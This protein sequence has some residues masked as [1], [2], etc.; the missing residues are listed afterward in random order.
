LPKGFL[1]LSIFLVILLSFHYAYALPKDRG[2][3]FTAQ[4]VE[5]LQGGEKLYAEGDIIVEAETYLLYAQRAIYDRKRDFLELFHFKLFDFS[6]NA[7]TLGEHAFFDLRN[8]ELMSSK[9]FI[10]FKKEG[11]RLKAWEFK[12]NALNEYFAQRALITTC[13]LDCEREEFPPWSVEVR[14]LILTPE[15]YTSSKATYFR[16]KGVPLLYLPQKVYLPKMSLPLFEP[17]KR[18]FLFPNISQGNRLGL[19]LQL[20]YFIPLTDQIDFTIAPLYTTKRGLLWDLENQFALSNETKGV[21]KVRYLEDTKR[22]EYLTT[23]VP[24]NRYWATGKIDIASGKNWDL[25][26]DIDFVSDKDFLEE[27]NVGEGSFDRAKGLYLERF[28]R[29]LEDKS[30]DYRTSKL[31]FQYTRNSL[32]TRLQSA[33]LDYEGPGNKKEVLQPLAQLRLNLLPFSFREILPSLSLDYH[34]FYRKENY[35]GHRWGL[36]LELAYPFVY[37]VL[38]N[39]F[40]VNYKNFLY[41]LEEEGNFTKK[42]LNQNLFEASFTSYTLLSK[43]YTFGEE[44]KGLKFQHVLKPYVSFFYRE[45]TPKR[46]ENPLF[47]YED[48]LV[49][50]AKALEYGIWQFINLPTQRNFLAIKAYQQYDFTK[51]ER[52]VLLTKPEDRALSDLYLQVLSQWKGRFSLRYD[53]AYNFYG[54]GLRKHSLNL[55]LREYILSSID[56]TYQEDEAWKTRQATLALAHL[57]RNNLALRYYVSRNLLKEETSE[58]KIEALYLHDCYLLGLGMSITPRDTKFYFKVDLKGLGGLGDRSMGLP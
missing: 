49:K 4:R 58:Q 35:Y 5:L 42:G 27:F 11:F 55:S 19:G 15:G 20:P 18:G 44:A 12:K 28:N 48:Y 51:A 3:E 2:F 53:T 33:Y 52:S 37:K 57:F 46:E 24:E 47:V 6:Q 36:N 7:T 41:L 10:F 56:F 21:F 38:K 26:L 22:G 54:Y 14:D 1:T 32:Y 8:N 23:K 40:K 17:R 43:H 45:I 50:K 34:Y 13:E 31:W 30:Q 9:V 39:E 16:A 29:D 25:H